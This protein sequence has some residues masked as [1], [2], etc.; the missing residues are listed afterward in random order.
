MDRSSH[1]TIENE[2]VV[3]K[4]TQNEDDNESIGSLKDFIVNDD[5]EESE[6][7]NTEDEMSDVD[8]SSGSESQGDIAE[9][10]LKVK[11]DPEVIKLLAE[12]AAEFTKSI[13][14]T[15]VGGRTLRSREPA[16]IEAR[17]PRDMYYERFG[18]KEEAKALEKFTKRDIIKWVQKLASEHKHAYEAAG[19]AWPTLNAR[20]SLEA[21]R[22]EYNKIKQFIGL[23][24]S[25][26]ETSD[27]ESI[28]S[29]DEDSMSDDASS[30]SDV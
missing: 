5:L 23:P 14:G 21:I 13:S 20:M 6:A 12:E 15:V 10:V 28:V 26:A 30:E 18:N 29:E 1:E 4:Y 16:K 9:P 17:K 24:D 2:S 7:S 25:D 8:E 22:N 19:H 3:E 27:A 11:E